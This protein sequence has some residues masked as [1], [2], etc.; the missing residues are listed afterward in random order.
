V[1]TSRRVAYDMIED[2]ETNTSPRAEGIHSLI[3][4]HI[5]ISTLDLFDAWQAMRPAV[6]NQLKE[7]KYMRASQQVSMPL[8]VSGVL[9]EAIRG[10]VSH[11]AL[12]KVL[13]QWQLLSKPLKA[14][15]TTTFTSSYGLPCVHTLKRLNEEGRALLLEH[16]HP[17]WHLKRD[18]SQ[19]QP[20]LE[21][22]A[23]PSKLNQRRNQPI[24]ST[25]REPSAFEG[26]E[27]TMRPKAQPKCSRCHTLGHIMTSKACPMRYEELFQ[28]SGSSTEVTAQ[29]ITIAT[30]TAATGV[31]SVQ[32]AAG[33]IEPALTAGVQALADLTEADQTLAVQELA[34]YAAASQTSTVEE[35]VDC[36]AVNST[37]A[38]HTAAGQT[39]AVQ[40]AVAETMAAPELRYDDPRAIYRRYVEAR[41]AWYNA[42][43]RGN[44]KTNQQYRKATGLPQ[45]Y[46]KVS[47]K[48]CLDWKQMGKQCMMQEGSRE[49]TTLR[50]R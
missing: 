22:K 6:T 36:I 1:A 29:T 50:R 12:R 15:C 24:T 10:W 27:A 28:L 8:D 31:A 3:K 17:H 23:V 38:V 34:D 35:V 26:V 39:A 9:F 13:E 46:D 45:R 41:Q 7:L 20:I 25:R 42:Q 48:W 44:I 14:S 47:Y 49:W 32:A 16:F 33:W 19:P 2:G 18:V 40:A 4:A 11:K 5:K 37:V 30:A 43:P 21:P